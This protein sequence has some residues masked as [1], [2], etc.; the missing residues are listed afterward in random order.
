MNK[1]RTTNSSRKRMQEKGADS[2]ADSS[3]AAGDIA[4][5]P[6][7]MF[8][9]RKRVEHWDNAVEQGRVALRNLMGKLQPFIH[10]PYFFSLAWGEDPIPSASPLRLSFTPWMPRNSC[11]GASGT[12]P[13]WPRRAKQK[14]ESL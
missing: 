6:D 4:S 9:R 12:E 7:Q 8:R 13:G 10:V 2:K 1:N 11:V 14:R 5:Y 3:W